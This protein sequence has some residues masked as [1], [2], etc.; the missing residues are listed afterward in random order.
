MALPLH[1]RPHCPQYPRR[2]ARNCTVISH[3][4]VSASILFKMR[5][6][7]SGWLQH[8]AGPAVKSPALA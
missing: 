7:A 5:F 6:E 4:D 2:C 3:R 1:A 8:E